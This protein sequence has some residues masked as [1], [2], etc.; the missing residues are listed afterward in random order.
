MNPEPPLCAAPDP[1]PRRPN[2]Q[3]PP[4]ACDCHAHIC[5]PP[6]RYAYYARR[7]YTPPD[8]LLPDYQRMLATLGVE[9]GVLV[10]PSVYGTDNS[11][12]LD[13]LAAA[14]PCFRGVAVV[15][16]ATEQAEL[17]RMHRIGVRGVRCNVVDVPPE[18]KGQLPLAS[19]TRL[20]RKI[21]RLGWH[22][23]LL[24]HVDEFPDFDRAFADFPV[25]VVVGHLGYMRTDRGL[26][27][28]GFQAMIRSMQSG[29]CW[30]KLTGPYRIAAQP[31]PHRDVIP[32]VRA[33]TDA[34]PDRV[35]WGTDWPHVM[36]KGGMPNDGDLCDLLS[37]WLLAPALRARVLTENP[38]RLYGF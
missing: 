24:L 12:L 28:P 27:A 18:E 1:H 8:A 29:R 22:I 9:R 30:A 26:G 10:Q 17:E 20:A 13:A 11:A 35:V 14:G 6:V 2:T 32:F 38:T 31:F 37:D 15:G 23:E 36:V 16:D 21:E 4:L 33:L 34:A 19:L 7:V 3:L 5:G 25:P